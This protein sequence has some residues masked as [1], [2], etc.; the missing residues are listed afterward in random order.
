[1]GAAAIA[2]S[3][4]L[5][6][7]GQASGPV[8]SATAAATAKATSAAATASAAAVARTIRISNT[9]ANQGPTDMATLVAQSLGFYKTDGL[10]AKLVD[11]TTSS[12]PPLFLSGGIDV[13]C[14]GSAFFSY[15][16]QG[17]D[18]KIVV[19]LGNTIPDMLLVRSSIQSAA[20][21]KGKVFGLNGLTGSIRALGDHILAADGLKDTDVNWIQIAGQPN[22]LAALVA[23][24]IDACILPWEQAIQSRSQPGVKILQKDP[25][26]G[27]F[28][29]SGYRFAGVKTAFAKANPEAVQGFVTAIIQ[30]HRALAKDQS[31][32]VDQVKA[33]FPKIPPDVATEMYTLSQD[34]GYFPVNGGVEPSWIQGNLDFYRSELV[35]TG[36]SAAPASAA[37]LLDTSY[38]KAALDK[39]GGPIDA[40]LDKAS[41]YKK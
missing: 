14:H 9:P 18:V 7:C 4:I 21:L 38:A 40:K 16:L 24:R 41:W 13:L 28:Q 5:A 36:A 25:T 15:A 32:Y 22:L 6:A 8:A 35:K 39:L 29:L 19:S 12:V 33:L 37:T 31:A 3:G 23:G 10:D 26:A 30:A 20:D 1:M 2:G 17:Q 34:V 27:G 11:G